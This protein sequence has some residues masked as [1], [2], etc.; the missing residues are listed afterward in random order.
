M[1]FYLK[2]EKIKIN[3]VK[4]QKQ[5]SYKIYLKKTVLQE[6][7]ITDGKNPS[8]KSLFSIYILDIVLSLEP[9]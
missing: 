9:F 5:S 6:D 4:N 3:F 1:L 8:V 7:K 2:K